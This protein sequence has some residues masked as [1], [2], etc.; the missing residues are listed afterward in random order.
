MSASENRT[1]NQQGPFHAASAPGG[2]HPHAYPDMSRRL[3]E[4]LFRQRMH[5]QAY[6]EAGVTH[7]ED[8]LRWVDRYV[9]FD[10]LVARIVGM[11][12]C[13]GWGYRNYKD[14]RIV[15]HRLYHPRLPSA[16]DGFRLLQLSDIHLDLDSSIIGVIKEKLAGLEY[17]LAV[18]TGDFR[19]TSLADHEPAVRETLSLLPAFETPV[20]GVLGNHDFIE[21][22]PPLE[23]VGLRFL[24][25]E[26]SVIHYNDARFY[27][28]G[29]DDAHFYKTHDLARVREAIP[30][31]GFSILLCHSPETYRQVAAHGFDVMLSGHTHGG[32]ICLPGGMVLL[33]VCDAPRRMLKGAWTFRNLVGYT[34]AGTGAC[35]VPLRFFCP[36]EITVHV[37]C[38]NRP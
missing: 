23:A 18:I 1:K 11:A 4:A 31:E 9:D 7:Q 17:D 30:D 28:A 34:S 36:P 8:F 13:F 38:S 19:N 3:G 29:V 16:L 6:H 24:L 2:F 26:V 33:R 10:K 37:L 25:N 20:Y 14:I 15:E 22:V 5:E 32:Q 12:G 27:L 35:G 21:I